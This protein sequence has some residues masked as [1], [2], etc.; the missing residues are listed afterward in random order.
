MLFKPMQSPQ[1]VHQSDLWYGMPKQTPEYQRQNQ[2]TYQTNPAYGYDQSRAQDPNLMGTD[3]YTLE[4][5][6]TDKAMQ[7]DYATSTV[8]AGQQG[9]EVTPQ[10]IEAVATQMAQ[11]GM[12][13][14]QFRKEFLTDAGIGQLDMNTEASLQRI[15]S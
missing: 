11:Q 9:V 6:L 8:A 14:D 13:G 10:Q 15:F 12:S 2:H 1:N 3:G 5:A 4:D 7:N